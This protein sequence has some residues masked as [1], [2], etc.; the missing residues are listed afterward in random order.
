MGDEW[1]TEWGTDGMG[2]VASGMGD[3][4]S[5]RSLCYAPLAMPRQ[6]RLDAFRTSSGIFGPALRPGS[7]TG[8]L[9][10]VMVRGLERRALFRDDQDRVDF[11]A[12]LAARAAARWQRV[13]AECR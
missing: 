2:D 9:Y 11:V 10:H 8:T 13:L 12:R 7:S 3:V 1:G 6:S 4:A 5:G